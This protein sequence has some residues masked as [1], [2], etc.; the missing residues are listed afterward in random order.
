MTFTEKSPAFFSGFD[1]AA[2]RNNITRNDRQPL[3]LRMRSDL[4]EEAVKKVEVGARDPGN[5]SDG[6]CIGEVSLVE[7]ETELAPMPGQNEEELI[8]LQG[9]IVMGETDPARALLRSGEYRKVRSPMSLRCIAIAVAGP[10]A[11]EKTN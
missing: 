7:R 4:H 1:G 8:A 3:I 9:S 5:R 6:L 2:G 10:I 11:L